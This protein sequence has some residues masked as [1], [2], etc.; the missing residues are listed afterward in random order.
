MQNKLIIWDLFGGGCN[1]ISRAINKY[2]LNNEYF[3]YTF[4]VVETHIESNRGQ[5]KYKFQK[6][7]NIVLLVSLVGN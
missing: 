2:G 7:I 5:L 3:V 4:D 1:S 6:Y